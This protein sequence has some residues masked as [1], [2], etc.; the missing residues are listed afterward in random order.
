MN[1]TDQKR[2]LLAGCNWYYNRVYYFEEDIRDE[3]I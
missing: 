3:K 1:G 2:G